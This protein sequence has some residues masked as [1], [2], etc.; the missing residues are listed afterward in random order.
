MSGT[1]LVIV[2]G[3]SGWSTISDCWIGNLSI[4]QWRKVVFVSKTLSRL[5]YILQLSLPDSVT[6][7]Y[8]H[9]L[10]ALQLSPHSVLLV[11]FG[12]CRELGLFDSVNLSHTVLI[13]LSEHYQCIVHAVQQLYSDRHCSMQWYRCTADI[14]APFSPCSPAERWW[15]VG[16]G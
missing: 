8:Y 5:V 11:I 16:G 3:D 1:L 7:R 15:T 9:S 13:E 6:E 10:S 4:R 2:G 12:G 14:T